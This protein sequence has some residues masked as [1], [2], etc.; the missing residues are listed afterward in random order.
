[1]P[2]PLG[3]IRNYCRGCVETAADIRTC[4]GDKMALGPCP[5][6]PYRLREGRPKL[7]TLRTFCIECMGGALSLVKDCHTKSCPIYPFRLGH[8]PAPETGSEPTFHRS[9]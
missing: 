9:R 3:A 6:H 8:R 5:F 1:M 7:R 4:G 2:S